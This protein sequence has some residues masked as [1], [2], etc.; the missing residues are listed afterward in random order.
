[1]I[2]LRTLL[3]TFLVVLVSGS[4]SFA[5]ATEA[6]TDDV[7][8]VL[9]DLIT[10][11]GTEEDNLAR[12]SEFGDPVIKDIVEAWRVGKVFVSP[13]TEPDTQVALLKTDDGFV[14]I[15]NGQAWQGDPSVASVNRASRGLRKQLSRLV[16]VLDLASPDLSKRADSAMKLGSGQSPDFLAELQTR[17]PK[18][19]DRKTRRAFEEAIAI[20]QLAN[21]STAEKIA[22]L[23][24]L[25]ERHLIAA[26]DFIKRMREGY[27]TDE[28][29]DGQLILVK[30]DAALASI[31]S[32]E[33]KVEFYGTLFRGLSL[34]SVLLIVAYGLAITFGLMGVINMAHGE[35]IAIG[36]YTVYVVQNFFAAHFGE[37]SSGYESYFLVSLPLAFLVAAFFGA[38]LERTVIRFLYKR[39]LESLLA[40]WG[41][42]MIIQQALRLKFGAANVSVASPQWLSGSFDANGVTMT[43]NR[44]F[45]IIFA[46]VV[47]LF[48]WLLLRRT[49]IGL[50]MRATMQNRAM[51]SG[52]G[53]PANRINVFTFAFGS[54]LAGLAGAFL[55]Q[56]GN[57]GPSMGQAYIVDSFMVVVIGGVGNLFGAAV[58]SLG[59]GMIDQSLQPILG[60]VMGKITVL[61]GIILFLQWRPGGLFPSR[62]RSLDD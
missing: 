39:P 13:G 18:Q 10:G 4:R 3:L 48:T 59:I 55:S 47:V 17:L 28:T 16:D 41:I 21:G 49:R 15:A 53:I 46:L 6:P 25:G 61:I 34:G 29:P 40:T 43:Y 44:I 7:R 54:G 37:A 24:L 14:N 31:A 30:A 26:R 11:N 2:A 19:T 42:S 62:S 60:P 12:L 45:V 23:E 9:T 51:A 27:T 32:F 35:F 57:V 58:S 56:I 36:A 38:V 1:M 50:H 20:S 33:K 8:S 22:S 5:Q 52:L